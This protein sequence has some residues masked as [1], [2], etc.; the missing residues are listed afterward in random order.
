MLHPQ[1]WAVQRGRLATDRPEQYLAAWLLLQPQWCV[2]ASEVSLLHCGMPASYIPLRFQEPFIRQS[3]TFPSPMHSSAMWSLA[4]ISLTAVPGCKPRRKLPLPS[5]FA[6]GEST[7]SLLLSNAA[8]AALSAAGLGF[9]RCEKSPPSRGLKAEAVFFS[10]K[11]SS[12]VGSA[13]P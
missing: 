2:P 8:L 5:E 1:M 7:D 6:L 10:C 4:T 13:Y 12:L 11:A 3:F 9:L